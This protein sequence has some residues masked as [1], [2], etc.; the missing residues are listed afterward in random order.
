MTG[1]LD[2]TST[3]AAGSASL[4]LI[5]LFAA[6]VELL[7]GIALGWWL[8]G[9]K[10]KTP[11]TATSADD[12]DHA[13]HAL[14][15]LH[16][17]AKRVQADVGAHSS[18]VEA[19]SNQLSAQ[20][21][22]GTEQEVNVLE[23][24]TKILEVN[25]RLEQQLQSAESKLHEQAEQIKLHSANALTDA[26]TGLGN[27]RAFD[28]E[29]ARRSAEFQRQGTTFCLLMLDVDHFK[30]F[31]DTHGHLAGDEVLRL[32][33]RTLKSAVRTP[34]FVARYGGE[35][36]GVIMPQT[37]L[38]ETPPCGERIRAAI[39]QAECEFEGKKLRVTASIG[40]AQSL[41]RQSPSAVV[42]SADEAL[43]AAKQGG[44][45]RVQLAAVLAEN[46]PGSVANS[47][48][49]PAI[50]NSASAHP[51]TT[52]HSP[53]TQNSPANLRTDTQ[54]GLP[55]RTAFCEDIRRR[56]AE[57]QRHGSRLS[58]MFIKVDNLSELTAQHGSL[59]GELVLRTC[60]QFLSAA[61][62]DM[63]LVARYDTD[64][65]GI[66]LPGTALVH[67]TGAGERL[68]SA[69]EHCPLRVMDTDIRFS[70]SVGVAEA[71]ATEDLVSFIT[72][73][74]A[75]KNTSQTEGGNRVHFHTGMSI[76]SLPAQAPSAQA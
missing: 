30:K 53:E 69:I 14:T 70:V 15:N 7:I 73:A 23:A 45:N 75:A 43:Y 29:L 74:E 21:S 22:D 59:L 2:P 6:A 50:E 36:F 1:P 62:R 16:E 19:I 72:R 60:T 13:Q 25:Q 24:V 67:A 48:A 56:L 57:T 5:G 12:I 8:R 17:L 31:N 64:V 26:L 63:D 33:G 65:F 68:R 38:P 44:R 54:T 49:E 27:R 61:M 55:N 76:E 4:I 10:N 20:Q 11:A 35:E 32:V 39:E 34:D 46:A 51:E 41:P 9:G 58:L 42:H 37:T 3:E 71:Q 47:P 66:V 18:Q 52:H 40:I 28:A